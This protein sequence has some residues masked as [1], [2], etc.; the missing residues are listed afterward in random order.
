MMP[1][2][3]VDNLSFNYER[4]KIFHQISF[5][6]TTGGIFCLFGPNGCGKSTLIECILGS[7]KPTEGSILLNNQSIRKIKPVELAKYIGYVPQSHTKNF[8][9]KV[10]DIVIMGRAAYTGTF[11]SP[12]T[13]DIAIAESALETLGLTHLKDKPYTQ[14]SGGQT[15]LVMLARALTQETPIILMDEPTAHLDFRHE[16][17]ILETIVKLIKEKNI[18]I[19]MATHFPNH[20]FYFENCGI[21][22]KVALM[23]NQAFEAIGNPTEVLTEANM[24]KTFNIHSKLISTMN[25][26]NKEVKGLIPIEVAT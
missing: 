26:N 25:T 5:E 21:N 9:Y 24:L 4:N 16:L 6:I 23:N 3:K 1:V 15:Q 20:A 19:I 7:L 14:L 13:E 10:I 18:S 8:P 22:T 17:I 12:S 2:L 11:S